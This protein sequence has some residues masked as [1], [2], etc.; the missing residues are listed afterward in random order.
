MLRKFKKAKFGLFQLVLVRNT[1]TALD[2]SFF[3]FKVSYDPSNFS[4]SGK[5]NTIDKVN[6]SSSSLR[7]TADRKAWFNNV[8]LGVNDFSKK[9]VIFL[10]IVDKYAEPNDTLIYKIQK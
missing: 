8:I 5:K 1:P 4:Q 7:E 10:M 2:P 9:P 3:D 6:F